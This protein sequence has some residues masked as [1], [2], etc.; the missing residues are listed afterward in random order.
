MWFVDDMIA[1][2][3]RN[4]CSATEDEV[5]LLARICD[6]ERINRHDIPRLL[7]KSYRK[8]VQDDD[9]SKIGT[10]K[11]VGIYSKVSAFLLKLGDNV[12]NA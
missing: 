2:N 1:K 12:K 9:F 10:L 11:R 8:C 6:D 4:E 5:R 7:R 3:N